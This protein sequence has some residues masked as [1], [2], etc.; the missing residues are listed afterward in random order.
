MTAGAR[1]THDLRRVEQDPTSPG[2]WSALGAASVV[3]SSHDAGPALSL[4][5]IAALSVV[6]APPLD[7]EADADDVARIDAE[8]G[9]RLPSE[10]LLG[11]R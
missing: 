8:V 10:D 5:Q 9:H 4:L 1:P 3:D 2:A 11:R 6:V 7:D